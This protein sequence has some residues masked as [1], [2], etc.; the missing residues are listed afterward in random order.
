ED[1]IRDRTVTGVQTCALPILILAKIDRL[2]HIRIGLRPGL[3]CFSDLDSRKFVTARSHDLRSADENVGALFWV[4][5]APAWKCLNGTRSEERRV[6]K[7]W[8][9]V[10]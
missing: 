7:E 2:T 1:G 3:A 10:G 5:V 8:R 6:G 4:D 9:S